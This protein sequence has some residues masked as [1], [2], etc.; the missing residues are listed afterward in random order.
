MNGILEMS[1]F[2]HIFLQNQHMVPI[3]YARLRSYF[4]FQG[5]IRFCPMLMSK[6][7]CG[8]FSDNFSFQ[9][10]GIKLF[11]FYINFLFITQSLIE[12]TVLQ[13][14]LFKN[15]DK[16]SS[17]FALLHSE[18]T[19]FQWS[20]IIAFFQRTY[21]ETVRFFPRNVREKRKTQTKNYHWVTLYPVIYF[22]DL[23]AGP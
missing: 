2:V 14:K 21:F 16:F 11:M 18:I 7:C 22:P 4:D 8:D 23:L 9:N 19:S 13:A 17:V 15:F 6:P 3:V 20:K 12:V 10:N 1:W 5:Q